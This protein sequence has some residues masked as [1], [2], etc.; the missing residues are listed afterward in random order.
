[1]QKYREEVKDEWTPQEGKEEETLKWIEVSKRLKYI[2]Y[3][4]R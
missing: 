4:L 3:V 2:K 1:M